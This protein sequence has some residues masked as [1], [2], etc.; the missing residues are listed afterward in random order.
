MLGLHI[1]SFGRLTSGYRW[2][3]LKQGLSKPITV[4]NVF[5][6]MD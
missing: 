2:K 1:I 3:V 5:S 4:M 6:L